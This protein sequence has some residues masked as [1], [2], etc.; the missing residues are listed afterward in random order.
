MRSACQH[1]SQPVELPG[2]SL[3]LITV[4]DLGGLN[5]P[6]IHVLSLARHLALLGH[7]IT[8]ISPQPSA[9]MPVELGTGVI[10]HALARRRIP[11]L[12]SIALLPQ[13]AAVMRKLPRPDAVYLR[14][15]VG[16]WPLMVLARSMWQARVVVEYNAWL[17]AD[18]QSMGRARMLA[19]AAQWLQLKEA[20]SA[21]A[22]R[23]V[24][25]GL[26]T[27]LAQHGI[28]RDKIA[29]IDNGSDIATFAPLDRQACRAS[30]GLAP[31]ATILAVAGNLWPALDLRLVFKAVRLLA[32]FRPAIELV[33][34]G[35]G[36]TRA[37]FEAA[38]VDILGPRPPIL[39][40]GARQ[41]AVVNE[42]LNAADVVLAPFTLQRNSITGLAPLKI[43][44]CAAAGR[45]CVASAITGIVDLGDEPWMFLAPPDDP[46]GFARAI[47]AAL[48]A[49]PLIVRAAARRYA[50]T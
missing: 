39:W 44:D 2:R 3:V 9:P 38:A 42:I 28:D 10:H 41:P 47:E 6:A 25:P 17:G 11:G 43:R 48:A 31:D 49:D 19:S 12:P 5:G 37:S 32:D 20:A 21:D 30:Y 34:V 46:A 23:A 13:L 15:S 1:Q 18:L 22:V 40:L 45:P 29:V 35:D 4:A 26:A 14:A 16:T 7:Q 33:I 24:T 50:E 36:I 8:L 27:L